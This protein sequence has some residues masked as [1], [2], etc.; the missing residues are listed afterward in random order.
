[1]HTI[2]V[3]LALG[4]NLGDRAAALAAAVER[5][6][7]LTGTA[8]RRE[9]SRIATK[10]VGGPPGQGDYLNSACFL[11]T[12]L[13][14]LEL[15]GETQ[16]IERELGRLRPET[17]RWG[18]RIIDIDILLYG[19]MLMDEE[20][21]TIPHPRLAERRFVLEPLAEIAGGVEVPGT[22]VRVADLLDRLDRR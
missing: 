20:A 12:T 2:P 15:L 21:L 11:T 17:E 19:D 13:E 5:L 3:Y 9:S 16:R 4:S 22:G 14:P 7:C 18:P 8:F 6:S 1:M 10:P